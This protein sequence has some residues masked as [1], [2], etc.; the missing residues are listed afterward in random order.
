MQPFRD[1]G[2]KLESDAP[3]TSV[4]TPP[5]VSEGA[6][7]S[8]NSSAD[9]SDRGG[10]S[11]SG[12]RGAVVT[13][14]SV[15]DALSGAPGER[16]AKVVV[17][18]KKVRIV[19][20]MSADDSRGG[21][22]KPRQPTSLSAGTSSQPSSSATGSDNGATV[23]TTS[24][25]A[26][27]N[28]RPS[29]TTKSIRTASEATTAPSTTTSKPV[30]DANS[31]PSAATTS[32]TKVPRRLANRR[33]LRPPTKAPEP[34]PTPTDG[35]SKGKLAPG[36]G[37]QSPTPDI[38][39]KTASTGAE[40]VV[41][42]NTT[43]GEAPETSRK[44][45]PGSNR[46]P[47]KTRRTQT[48]GTDPKERSRGGLA[49]RPARRRPSV[50]AQR[51]RTRL[52]GRLTRVRPNATAI[53]VSTTDATPAE[54]ADGQSVNREKK[55]VA[56]VLGLLGKIRNRARTRPTLSPARRQSKGTTKSLASSTT[57]PTA[58][59]L[60]T[61]QGSA[62]SETTSTSATTKADS[63]P[64]TS[65]S[66]PLTSPSSTPS[67]TQTTTVL[68]SST[69][70]PLAADVAVPTNVNSG[71]AV[72]R[73]PQAR[74]VTPAGAGSSVERR[75][76]P[77]ALRRGSA[78]TSSDKPN[79]LARRL[80]ER[81]N[82][83]SIRGGRTPKVDPRP[84]LPTNAPFPLLLSKIKTA[85][86]PSLLSKAPFVGNIAINVTLSSPAPGVVSLRP[87]APVTKPPVDLSNV[88]SA[89]TVNNT[90]DNSNVRSANT[91]NSTSDNSNVRSAST[92][93]S[94]SDNSNVRSASDFN[95]KSDVSNATN[96]NIPNNVSSANSSSFNN[97]TSV[98]DVR[99]LSTPSG[100]SDARKAS[101]NLTSGNLA[102][103]RNT[104][105]VS[106][107]TS[108]ED[109][110]RT[111]LGTS[112]ETSVSIAVSPLEYRLRKR[113]KL[114]VSLD[115]GLSE[116]NATQALATSSN[117]SRGESLDG[118]GSGAT[119][120]AA[121]GVTEKVTAVERVPEASVPKIKKTAPV[122]ESSVLESTAT[123]PTLRSGESIDVG[124]DTGLEANE[125]SIAS[126]PR[127]GKSILPI[128][129]RD[130]PREIAAP[131][132]SAR[133]ETPIVSETDASRSSE[134]DDTTRAK[135]GS[136]ITGTGSTSPTPE[137][138]T[139]P[140]VENHTY[141]KGILVKSQDDS[142]TET[143]AISPALATT[144]EISLNAGKSSS[145]ASFARFTDDVSEPSFEASPSN[146]DVDTV[147]PLTAAASTTMTTMVRPTDSILRVLTSEAMKSSELPSA[148]S[149][150]SASADPS[151]SST[152]A[153][154]PETTSHQATVQ[155]VP[156][157][158]VTAVNEL[159]AL[160]IEED[161]TG[162]SGPIY[163]V[164]LLFVLPV[165]AVAL[166]YLKKNHPDVQHLM[167][168][169]LKTMLAQETTEGS[170]DNV[171]PVEAEETTR[172]STVSKSHAHD[173]LARGRRWE[174][175]R[176]TLRLQSILGEGHFGQVWRAEVDN[177]G[178][179]QGTLLVAV[180][181][182]KENATSKEK[183]DLLRELRIMQD[184]GSHPNVVT[185]LGCCTVEDPVL[186]IMEYMVFGKLL[187]YLRENRG[188]HNYYNFSHD[189]A[190]LTSPDLTLFACQ[191]A[192]GMEYIA[193]KGIIHRD[194]AARNILVDH[195]K[196]C[197]VSDF[198]MSRSV[199]E[200]SAEVFEPKHRGALP[201]RWMSPE[202]LYHNTFNQ[203]TDCWSFGILLWEIITLGSTPYPGL[204]AREVMRSV[205]EGYRLE[206]PDHCHPQLYQLAGSC[207]AAEPS[208]RPSFVEL[209]NDLEVL[210][211]DQNQGYVDLDR[212]QE[213]IYGTLHTSSSDEKV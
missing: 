60:S 80:Q 61:T 94:T 100:L 197:K 71:G 210:L 189:S 204:S 157:V 163:L 115:R 149:S 13:N 15:V 23:R 153:P 6:D 101:D 47:V 194:L 135:P 43:L 170:Q 142:T 195:T 73:S 181:N 53:S 128:R 144:T 24:R 202:S 89:R 59:P 75:K 124:E 1:F 130:D 91:V 36:A 116:E 180:K 205:R 81:R 74:P 138:Y 125:T 11:D 38:G 148:S 67:T 160:D 5:A 83:F 200:I 21:V 37:E 57:A 29:A 10:P 184:L 151:A 172:K 58:S 161:A 25:S 12:G 108:A 72:T 177:I 119:R 112:L 50:T 118:Q 193:N 86:S 213:E 84:L 96:V 39:K 196:V 199:K 164:S 191:V 34:S 31:S 173:T 51:R 132:T 54:D 152:K 166:W 76:R 46:S 207:W 186:V 113:V 137:S 179:H 107:P 32:G 155:E 174:H 8:A 66:T 208:W 206:R 17:R 120:T 16:H 105:K 198:G 55:E 110:E 134:K 20:T 28:T 209:R 19:S 95:S 212:F 102:D 156:L 143:S 49:A 147:E 178:G 182:V 40:A 176:E 82:I 85:L 27:K 136:T 103:V 44:Q 14:E 41:P 78:S 169:R 121:R 104:T 26:D 126:K 141:L 183:Q 123:P 106:N 131:G 122:L 4:E 93:N 168:E 64:T 18:R 167:P 162:D 159:A 42:H 97:V 165:V 158:R 2:E 62:S 70:S 145:E 45:T 68:S 146:S 7:L 109:V 52:R 35:E 211:E 69:S 175:P 9:A 3:E 48:D 187:T 171:Y 33:L 201:I 98:G 127:T 79:L 90:S 117:V 150:S 190:V 192:A 203:Q 88:G 188:R 111:V 87:E 114:P 139:E 129:T 185:L 77:D 63:V 22:R 92:V 99:T 30:S 140:A 154:S 133:K 65:P 56:K